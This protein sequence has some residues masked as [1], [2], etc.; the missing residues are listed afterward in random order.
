MVSMTVSL[1]CYIEEQNLRYQSYQ[2]TIAR[3]CF[4][5]NNAR[6][7]SMIVSTPFAWSVLSRAQWM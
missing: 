7:F 1:G 4:H 6:A 5:F 3:P 2:R